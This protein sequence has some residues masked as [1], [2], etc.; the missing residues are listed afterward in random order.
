MKRSIFFLIAAIIA[1]LFG[2]MMLLAPAKAAEGFG[3]LSTP[4]STI[5]FRALGAMIF[6]TGVMNFLVRNHPDNITLKMVLLTNLVTHTLSTVADLWAVSDGILE[7]TKAAP[8]LV[9]HL[10]IGIGSLIYAMKIKT[11]N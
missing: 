10:L 8:G 9:A 1:G 5:L 6:S 2:G 3:I 4:E 7:I 11:S